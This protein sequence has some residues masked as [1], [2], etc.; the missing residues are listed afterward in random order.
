MSKSELEKLLGRSLTSV[1]SAGCT[2]YL[3]ISKA[4]L[5]E[6]LCVSLIQESGERV[7]ESRDGYKTL[8]TGIFNNV[9]SVSINGSVVDTEDYYESF[10]DD[11]NKGF[12]NSI[13]FKDKLTT[14]EVSVTADWGFEETPIDLKQF[15]AQLFALNAKK[16]S[17]ESVKSKQ[18]EDFRITYRDVTNMDQLIADNEL[19]M[20]KYGM[21]D[22]FG[23]RHGSVCVSHGVRSCVNCL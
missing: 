3:K 6:L 7:F 8:F 1:E 22:I 5:E 18:V 12:Y 14:D 10:F 4:Q 11:R 19:I 23:T 15:L 21:C 9:S 20:S 17:L 2:T 16:R 13:V